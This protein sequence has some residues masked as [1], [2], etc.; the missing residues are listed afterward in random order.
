[1]LIPIPHPAP[2]TSTHRELWGKAKAGRGAWS[3][4]PSCC[5]VSR[6]FQIQGKRDLGVKWRRA[7]EGDKLRSAKGK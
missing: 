7:W 6:L 4:G 1:M 5:T 2:R 3:Q